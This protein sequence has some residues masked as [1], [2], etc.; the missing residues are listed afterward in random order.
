MRDRKPN[1]QG[2]L[3]EEETAVKGHLVNPKNI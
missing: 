3:D 2:Y 1:L